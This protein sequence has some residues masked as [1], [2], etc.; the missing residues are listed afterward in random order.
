[1]QANSGPTAESFQH[2]FND[3]W[4]KSVNLF[5][6]AADIELPNRTRQT[7][8]PF[9]NNA[10]HPMAGTGAGAMFHIST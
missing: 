1:M 2:P 7:V 8:V 10:V 3:K 5:S 6:V 4:N 9:A